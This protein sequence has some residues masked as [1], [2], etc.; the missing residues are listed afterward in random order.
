M[1]SL[2]RITP[3]TARRLCGAGQAFS[4]AHLDAVLKENEAAMEFMESDLVER[5]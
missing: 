2:P 3:E 1:S 5:L 4:L